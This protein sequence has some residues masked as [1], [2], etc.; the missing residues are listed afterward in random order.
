MNG[1]ETQGSEAKAQDA[2][3]VFGDGTLTRCDSSSPSES[4]STAV[5]PGSPPEV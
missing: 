5:L 2:L 4:T 1:W 3:V